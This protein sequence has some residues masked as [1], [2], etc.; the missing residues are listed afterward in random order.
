[1]NEQEFDFGSFLNDPKAIPDCLKMYGFPQQEDKE[2]SE[3]EDYFFL[4]SMVAKNKQFWPQAPK[5]AAKEQQEL[6][7]KEVLLA[8]ESLALK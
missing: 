8:A 3:L 1:M 6:A 5:D 4:A 7:E 2:Q